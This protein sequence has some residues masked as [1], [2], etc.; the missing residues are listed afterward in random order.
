MN[1]VKSLNLFGV[2]A[3]EIPSIAGS[4]APTTE[5]EGAVGCLYMDTDTGAMYKCIAVTDGAYEWVDVNDKLGDIETALDSIIAIQNE[6]IGGGE[7]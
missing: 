4:G 6:L 2:E 3:K 7:S 5:T 1:Y